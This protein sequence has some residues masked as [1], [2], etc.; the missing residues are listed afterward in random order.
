VTTDVV[1]PAILDAI[2]R[3][4][5]D[6][7]DVAG[8]VLPDEPDERA[9]VRFA[10][11]AWDGI[12]THHMGPADVEAAVDAL[13]D[14]LSAALRGGDGWARLT[15]LA[16]RP[17][18]VGQLDPLLERLGRS[19]VDASGLHGL[20]LRLVST[21]PDRGPVKLG[22]ALLGLFPADPHREVLLTLGRHDEFTLYAAVALAN[23]QDDPVDDLWRLARQVHGWGRVHLVERLAATDRPDVLDWIL[24]EGFRNSVTDEYL[25]HLA[26]TRGHLRARLEPGGPAPAAEATLAA[27]AAPADEAAPAAEAAPA[28]G[29]GRPTAAGGADGVD[30]ELLYAAGDLLVALLN[31][32]PAADI[33]DYPDG[34]AVAGRYLDLML[35]RARD[36]RHL[37]AVA[38]VRDFVGRPEPV[39]GWP[40]GWTPTVRERLAGLSAAIMSRPDWADL[41]RAQL[42]SA[43]RPTFWRAGRACEIL[44]LSTLPAVLARLPADPY[45]SAWWYSATAQLDEDAV[46]EVVAAAGRLLPLADIAAGPSDEYGLGPA[47]A[48]HRCLD[49]LLQSLDAWPGRGWPLLAAGL[50]SPVVRN[51]NLAVR[52]LAAW[53]RD[54]WPAGAEAALRAAAA[55]EPV[56]DVRQRMTDVLSPPVGEDPP[57]SEDRRPDL[58]GG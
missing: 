52:A 38:K 25:A 48:P 10:A 19:D 3:R 28:D 54:T 21:S 5:A 4:L 58:S 51:R 57:V 41:A 11:G 24:R 8:L 45:E 20:A 56:P 14:A 44:G 7:E 39:R 6:G 30:D 27:E 29:A 16:G 17:G 13:A 55:A 34:A 1:R 49:I 18:L 12:A 43:D 37:L 46:D 23:G 9:G 42:W 33:Y 47:W 31:G 40:E 53:P 36:L 15:E 50:A 2:R 35:T 32:G 22:I 26:A